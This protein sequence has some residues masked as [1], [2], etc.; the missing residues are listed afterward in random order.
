MR[1]S[2]LTLTQSNPGLRP[3]GPPSHPWLIN[4]SRREFQAPQPE[5]FHEDEVENSA[6]SKPKWRE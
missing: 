6:S 4:L 5:Q 1:V 3:L 2:F